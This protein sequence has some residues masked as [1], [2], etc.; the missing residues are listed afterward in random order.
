M[1][2]YFFLDGGAYGSAIDEI[3]RKCADMYTPGMYTEKQ[4]RKLEKIAKKHGCA[5]RWEKVGDYDENEDD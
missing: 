2:D 4:K 3:V 1:K 5:V